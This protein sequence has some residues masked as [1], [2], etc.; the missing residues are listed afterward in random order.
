[1]TFPDSRTMTEEEYD[2]LLQGQDWKSLSKRLTEFAWRKIHKRSWEDAEDIAQTALRRVFDARCQRWN[3]KTQPNIF[4]FLGNMVPGILA[5]ERRKR[6]AGRV[7]TPY[8]H[9]D[10]EELASEV[11]EATLEAT[12]ETMARRE[13]A[14]QIVEELRAQVA[15][16]RAVASVLAAFEDE[17]DDPHAQAEA[18]GLAMQAVYNARSKLRALATQ[19]AQSFDGGSNEPRTLQ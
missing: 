16:E 6:R 18:T 13:R 19:I 1:M 10:L 11:F 15:G 2:D 7:E 8:E 3:P 4:W 17:I 5:N 12:D 9:E 14:R